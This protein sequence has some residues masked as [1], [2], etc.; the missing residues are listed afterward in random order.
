MYIKFLAHGTGDP[1]KA[2]VYLIAT[3]DHNKVARAEVRV[4]RGNPMLVAEVAS[5]LKNVHRYTS[6]VISWHADDAPT[7]DE[8]N[9]VVDDFERVAFSGLEPDQYCWCVILHVD[10][11]GTKHLHVFA[12]R[13]ELRSGKA[14]NMAPPGWEKAFDSL[15]DAWNF[16]KGWARPDDPAR[17]R[18]VQP[19]RMAPVS[20]ST[21]SCNQCEVDRA[22][23]IGME[24]SDIRDVLMVEPDQKM[25]IADWLMRRIRAGE[26]KDRQDIL[27]ALGE[28]GELNRV[29]KEYISVRLA[30]GEK[31]V[32]LKGTLFAEGFDAAAILAAEAVPRHVVG[33]GRESPNPQAAVAARLDL[34]AAIE[35][36]GA[37]NRGRYSAPAPSRPASVATA[38]DAAEMLPVDRP[39]LIEVP[40]DRTRNSLVEAAERVFAAARKSVRRL[41]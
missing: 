13:V 27:D 18:L 37:Y 26:I 35:R 21:A 17:A 20:R 33:G 31:P 5:S 11:D 7:D 41:V 25:I 9:A 1:L 10:Q 22:Q 34:A 36:R 23:E 15:R 32:R 4:L 24:A 30:P 3:H 39:D 12:A 6:G 16:E 29:S 28:L 38:F 8:I 19:G 2:A 14:F 40:R